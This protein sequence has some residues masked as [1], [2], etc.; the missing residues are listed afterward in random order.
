M[1]TIDKAT[2]VILDEVNQQVI[3]NEINQAWLKGEILTTQG[4]AERIALALAKEGRLAPDLPEPRI[5][6]PNT[7]PDWAQRYLDEW[8]WVPDVE[9][10]CESSDFVLNIKDGD[11]NGGFGEPQE[12]WLDLTPAQLREIASALLAAADYQEKGTTNV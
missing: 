5:L 1:T 9:F 3:L 10:R 12:E 11:T 8:E 6:T 7:D 4:V 2:Q